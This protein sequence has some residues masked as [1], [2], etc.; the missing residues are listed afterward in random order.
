MIIPLEDL[1][2]IRNYPNIHWNTLKNKKI[3]ITGASGFF[4][5][6]IVTA[7]AFVSKYLS[8][9]IE[10]YLLGRDKLKLQK[11]FHI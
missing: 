11:G 7:L 8:L 10:L 2:Y 3:F 4:G 5:I 9:N 6:W 1:E